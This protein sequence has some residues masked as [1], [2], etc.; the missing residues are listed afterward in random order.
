LWTDFNNDFRPDLV[1]AGEWMPLVFFENRNGKLVRLGNPFGS[2][3]PQGWWTSLAAADFDNDGDTDYIAGNIGTNTY[4]QCSAGEPVRVYAKDFDNNG[5]YDPFISC[6]WKDSLGRKYEYFYHTRD[7][8]LK[9]LISLRK[10]FN[11]Y[12]QLGEAAVRDVFTPKELEGAQILE[13]DFMA[14]CLVE[15]LGDGKFRLTTLPPV[16]QVAPIFGVLPRDVNNDGITDLI[17]TGNDY[18]M[19]LIQGRADASYGLVLINSGNSFRPLEPGESG[20]SVSGDARALVSL[21]FDNRELLVASQNAAPLRVFEL[22]HPK[23]VTPVRLTQ[24]E[25]TALAVFPDGRKSRFEF[26]CGNGFLSQSSGIIYVPAGAQS[27]EIYNSKGQKTRTIQ[28][29]ELIAR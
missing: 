16:A 20:F 21:F 6:Y 26:Y 1:I 17:I 24:Q 10:K 23:S 28:A 27:I 15:N 19:E 18:G 25:T 13:A 3:D 11:G 29:S 2:T 5:V 14:S 8:M 22:P 9:Q 4:F 12:G 7:D